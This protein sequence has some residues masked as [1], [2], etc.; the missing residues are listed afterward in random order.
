MAGGNSA[1]QFTKNGVIGSV[2]VT[3]ANTSSAGGGTIGTDIF[4]FVTADATYGTFVEFVRCIA[5]ATAATSTT[6]SVMRI[7]ASSVTSGAT[8]S[9]NTILIAEVA[10]PITAA[11]NATTAV[12]SIDIPCNF[13]L[14]AGWTLLAT[15]HAA[16]AANTNWRAIAFGGDY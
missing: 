5:V 2:L 8:T 1:P 6:A 16:P 14:P 12:N 9:A 11:D 10:I 4:K 3:A 13:R 7:F 15:N